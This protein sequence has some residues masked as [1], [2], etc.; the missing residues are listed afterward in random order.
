MPVLQFPPRATR[1]VPRPAAN[2][3]FRRTPANIPLRMANTA[4]KRVS[5]PFSDYRGTTMGSASGHM[6][7]IKG[8]G[9]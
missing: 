1:A 6:A 2:N 7:S 9:S 4:N 8:F 5:T 3:T